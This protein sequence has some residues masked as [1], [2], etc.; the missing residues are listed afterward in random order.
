MRIL[1]ALSPLLF[2]AML[3]CS[4]FKK[5]QEDIGEAHVSLF[6][7]QDLTGWIVYGREKWYI[8]DGD[9]VCESGPYRE[10]GYLGTEE[11]F[12][13]FDLSLEFKQEANGNSGVF[14]RSSFE[15]VKVAGWQAEI[16]PRGEHTGGIYE[17][18]ERG[19]LIKPTAALDHVLKENE[20][21][22][23]RIR[24]V[25]NE[26]TTWLNGIRMIR[27]KDEKIGQAEGQI[28]LQIHDGGGIK[29]RWRN[30]R[31]KVIG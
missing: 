27:L 30:I 18:Y 6:N 2:A 14:F 29:V 3:S 16:A 17:S 21:N 31:I 4:V 7:G 10:Y 23:L 24:C 28:A 22:T 20:W 8:E 9:L 26:V 11:S 1:V 19:W 15:G 5:S 12:K 25:G 13:D